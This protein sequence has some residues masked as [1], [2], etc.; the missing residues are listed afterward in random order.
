MLGKSCKKQVRQSLED[1]GPIVTKKALPIWPGDAI[2]Q[3]TDNESQANNAHRLLLVIKG[4]DESTA[5]HA[6]L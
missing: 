6:P 2:E 5:K 4:L 1:L 3:T